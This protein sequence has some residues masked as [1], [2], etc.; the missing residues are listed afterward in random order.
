MGD[1]IKSY[2]PTA[3]IVALFIM[4][5]LGYNK[6]ISQGAAERA[7]MEMVKHELKELRSEQKVYQVKIDSL[8]KTN[9]NL[10]TKISKYGKDMEYLK[11][12]NEAIYSAYRSIITERPEF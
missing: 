2:A 1:I 10:D 4:A 9:N 3:L 6:V 11:G 12:Q 8:Q 7:E 5:Y